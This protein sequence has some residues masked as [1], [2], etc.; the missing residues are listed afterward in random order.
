MLPTIILTLVTV[1]M[2]MSV[3]QEGI[4]SKDPVDGRCIGEY[5]LTKDGKKC[6]MME[7][8]DCGE[9]PNHPFGIGNMGSAYCYIFSTLVCQKFG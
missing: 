3:A 1:A 7:D 6:I 9:N 8:I 5:D 4:I 2:S